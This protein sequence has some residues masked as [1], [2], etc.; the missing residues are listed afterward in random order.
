MTEIYVGWTNAYPNPPYIDINTNRPAQWAHSPV[1]IRD[2]AATPINSPT[3]IGF[4]CTNT[5]Q[6]VMSGSRQTDRINFGGNW[7]GYD[8]HHTYSF[9]DGGRNN[10]TCMAQMVL[11]RD[12]NVSKPHTGAVKQYQEVYGRYSARLNELM[13]NDSINAA[14]KFTSLTDCYSANA[15][16]EFEDTMKIELPGWLKNLYTGS[17]NA[18][19]I[20]STSDGYIQTIEEIAPLTQQ[21]AIDCP[22]DYLL[23]L[24][25]IK[26]KLSELG[27]ENAVPFA[28][29][30]C[31]NVFVA[32]GNDIYFFDDE[33]DIIEK[34]DAV[35]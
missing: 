10:S 29:D 8:L 18:S 24:S 7:P 14:D 11:R 25:H 1:F 15:I 12:H 33:C 20:Y 21:N 4:C 28:F 27:C 34:V 26:Q 13:E 3:N 22:M 35:V 2:A 30:P 17:V 31:G 32:A 6:I 16:D 9:V 19:R 5:V 23:T